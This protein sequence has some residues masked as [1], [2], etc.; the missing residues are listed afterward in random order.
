LDSAIAAA[1]EK[2]FAEAQVDDLA[3]YEAGGWIT[4]DAFCARAKM[5]DSGARA[6]L[7][8]MT[9]EGRLEHKK[10]RCVHAGRIREINI[11]RPRI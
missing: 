7:K 5:S 4:H 6:A 3:A 9:G 11:Y 8:K 2:V 1:W 10:I